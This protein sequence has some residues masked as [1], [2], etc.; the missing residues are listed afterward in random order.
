[1]NLAV[2]GCGKM[3]LPLAV[4]AAGQGMS[5]IGVDRS[6]RVVDAIN[7]GE[8][9]ID[10][11]GV[12]NLLSRAVET[13][14]LTASTDLS[15]AVSQSDIILVI[16]P[17]LLNDQKQ[18]D[19][20][21][22]EHVTEGISRSMKPGTLVTFETTLPV[23]TTRNLLCPL[24]EK[25][26]RLV[27]EDFYLVFSPERVKS[28]MV[29]DRLNAVPK[30]VGGAGPRSLEKGVHFYKR[31]LGCDIIPMPSLEAAE[32]VK[33]AGMLYRDVNI[34]LVN[35][36]SRYCDRMGLNILDIIEAA[37]TNG[38]AHLLQPGIGV[39]GHCT[40][41]Y[42]YFL[43]QDARRRGVAQRL[44]EMA[45]D[46]NDGQA[47]HALD[48]LEGLLGDLKG[49][50]L[51]ILGL[52]FRPGVKEDA[53][54]TAYLLDRLA[55]KRGATPFLYDPLY[56]EAEISERGFA[57]RDLYGTEPTDAIVLVT[58]HESF[59]K[60][61]WKMLKDA[62]VR[63]LVDGRNTIDRKKVEEAG[64]AYVGIGTG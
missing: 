35:E 58:A 32:M 42:P 13:G 57:Y 28:Q 1:M 60:L 63:A 64:I 15:Q 49:L 17:V 14:H 33:L 27:E 50:R 48:R 3:G 4:Q 18:A 44:P 54:S 53:T 39:G 21:I 37:N 43:I 10:E 7:R 62:G 5:V 45:R 26:G 47:E 51:L 59:L 8:S 31:I 56:S 20:G 38:E 46:I 34:A 55:R 36:M 30:V 24:L 52:G 19:L 40:P 41:V 61:D 22:L 11:P 2:I 23:G 12:A 16:V 6:R 25:Q 9:H 29:L